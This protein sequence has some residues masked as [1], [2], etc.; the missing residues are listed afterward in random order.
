MLVGPNQTHTMHFPDFEKGMLNALSECF[1]DADQELCFF[2]YSQAVY[3]NVEKKGL[4]ALYN[5]PQARVLL[6]CFMSLPML[7]PEEVIRGYNDVCQA[8]KELV[9]S[10]TVPRSFSTKLD[11]RH[12]P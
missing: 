8:F 12:I 1:P 10:G 7:P 6:R 9:R 2:H 4:L 11:S 5:V 3:R